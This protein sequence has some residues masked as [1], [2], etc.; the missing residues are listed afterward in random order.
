[1]RHCVGLIALLA[2]SVPAAADITA[3]FI[4]G[5]YVRTLSASN[6]KAAKLVAAGKVDPY[7]NQAT[8]PPML[9]SRGIYNGAAVCWYTTANTLERGQ[10][11]RTRV[12]C[13]EASDWGQLTITM[14][15][16]KGGLR[17]FKKE[18]EET[19]TYRRC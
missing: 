7:A 2:G 5:A 9:D 14:T 11:W 4:D 13:T 12:H 10:R 18:T 6:C 15:R 8:T 16:I 17:L 3:K 1:M 19:E